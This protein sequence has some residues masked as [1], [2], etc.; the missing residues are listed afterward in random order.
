M[1]RSLGR[2]NGAAAVLHVTAYGRASFL[3]AVFCYASLFKPGIVA[4]LLFVCLGAALV[5]GRGTMDGAYLAVLA[6]TG[7]MAAGGAGALNHY[8]DRDI[9]RLMERTKRRPLVVGRIRRPDLVLALGIGLIVAAARIAAAFNWWL[10]IFLL[11]GSF[12]YVVIYTIW[13]KRRTPWGVVVGG[14]AGSLAVL[15]G[16]TMAG[17]WWTP[18]SLLTAL[19]VFLW[20]PPHFWA[21]ATYR[22]EDYR[23]AKVPM[24]PTVAGPRW[25]A[26]WGLGHVL[27]LVVCSLILVQ[28]GSFGP[29][30]MGVALGVG[31][32]FLGTAVWLLLWPRALTARLHFRASILH[33]AAIFAAM[34]ADKYLAV[35]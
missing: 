1:N 7:A 31:L 10:A 29:L 13:L 25:A 11:A 5:A 9:D 23:R 3:D 34:I 24:L 8:L 20:T 27:L 19:L 12:V 6:L 4:L 18:Q 28:V 14:T 32:L 21:L 33:L 30:Y 35:F 16:W 15:S 17:E 22:A 26:A 2:Q